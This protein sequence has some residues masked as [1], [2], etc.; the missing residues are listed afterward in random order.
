MY[1][2]CEIKNSV[3][4]DVL[5]QLKKQYRFRFHDI[6]HNFEIYFP[7][8]NCEINNEILVAVT[9]CKLIDVLKLDTK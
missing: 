8:Q 4:I 7:Y 5:L 1:F 6:N 9:I 2:R 3:I